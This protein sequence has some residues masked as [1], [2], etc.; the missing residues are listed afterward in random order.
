MQRAYAGVR[1]LHSTP[2][3]PRHVALQTANWEHSTLEVPALR[4]FGSVPNVGGCV[5]CLAPCTLFYPWTSELAPRDLLGLGSAVTD[6]LLRMPLPASLPPW[7]VP[8]CAA[9]AL[10]LPQGLKEANE[11]RGPAAPSLG[12]HRENR[13]GVSRLVFRGPGMLLR[14]DAHL[15]CARLWVGAPAPPKPNKANAC[16]LVLRVAQILKAKRWK[17]PFTDGSVPPENDCIW[18]TERRR[19]AWYV[20]DP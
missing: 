4:S 9:S 20:S 1:G 19:A 7:P 10:D 2:P 6:L 14:E 15:A 11:P 5:L 3:L 8:G 16:L 18:A 12:L 13:H 17:Q